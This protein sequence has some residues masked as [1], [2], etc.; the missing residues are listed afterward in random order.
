MPSQAVIVSWGPPPA[1]SLR[2]LIISIQ[3]PHNVAVSG[4][5][6]G[7]TAV[8]EKSIIAHSIG[9]A[10]VLSTAPFPVSNVTFI[11]TN[12]N[13]LHVCF[14]PNILYSPDLGK[15]C[16]MRQ[17]HDDYLIHFNPWGTA[18]DTWY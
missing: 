15:H 6:S 12:S 17:T 16:C 18:V 1:S 10:V 4:T 9:S 3:V 11:F 7:L 5:S 13:S 8:T 14:L 2:N